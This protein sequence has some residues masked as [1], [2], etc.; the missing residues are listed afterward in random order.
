MKKKIRWFVVGIVCCLMLIWGL[1]MFSDYCR[2]KDKED[3]FFDISMVLYHVEDSNIT[4]KRYKGLFYNVDQ[5][6]YYAPPIYMIEPKVYCEIT[7]FNKDISKVTY[8]AYK[9]FFEETKG[10]V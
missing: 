1:M 10:Q 6:I 4:V 7:F 8:N 3:P 9:Q 5:V 2:A